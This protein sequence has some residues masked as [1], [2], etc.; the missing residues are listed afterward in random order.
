MSDKPY[1]M[2]EAEARMVEVLADAVLSAYRRD[3]AAFMRLFG[4][5]GPALGAQKVLTAMVAAGFV[6]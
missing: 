5:N 4:S 2:N 3:D 6:R 1:V